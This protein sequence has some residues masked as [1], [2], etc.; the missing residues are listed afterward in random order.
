MGFSERGTVGKRKGVR[1]MEREKKGKKKV[2][3]GG[4]SGGTLDCGL[5]KYC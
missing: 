1:L 3:I 5:F 2:N 4:G